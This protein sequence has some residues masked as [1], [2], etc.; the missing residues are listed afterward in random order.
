M[1]RTSLLATLLALVMASCTSEPP[2]PPTRVMVIGIDGGTWTAIDPLMKAGKLPN[3]RR[4]HDEGLH[5]ILE[6]RPPILSPVVWTTIFTGFGHDKHGVKD[7]KTSQSVHRRVSALWEITS[8]AKRKTH[9]FNVPGSWPPEPVDGVMVSGFPL[10]GSTLLGNTGEVYTR[11]GL[12]GKR[13][14]PPVRDNADLLR[15]T[16]DSLS[17][18]QW[19]PW[20][21]VR[22]TN[23]PNIRGAMRVLRLEE[24]K[25]YVSP[26]YRADDGIV[27]TSPKE[28]RGQL[29]AKLG[30]PY[31]P[32]GPGWSRWEEPDTP[33]F[34]ADHLDQV[35]DIQTKAAF[36][37]VAEDWQAFLYVMTLVDRVSHPYWAYSHPDDYEGLDRAKAAKY[38]SAVD[39]A[40]IRS[41]E[42]LGRFLAKAKEANKGDFYV[43]I[44]SDHGFQSAA[45]GSKAIGTH[46]P[47]GIF[48]LH[49]PG[50][51]AGESPR[52]FIEDVTPT[53]LYLMNLPIGRDM[54][55]QLMSAVRASLGREPTFV[56]SYE[57]AD[58]GATDVP[59]DDATWE[60]L[61][62]LG[63]VDGAP[64]RQQM[65]KDE[66][67]PAA[68]KKPGVA[69]PAKPAAPKAGAAKPPAPK[70]PGVGANGRQPIPKKEGGAKAPAA[71]AN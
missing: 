38:A 10:S 45:G 49:G 40:Y 46:N 65:Q 22:V 20:L 18:G 67:K 62:G 44:V 17:I 63:Y 51:Q 8:A 54:E 34:L 2:P 21:D 27:M 31:I 24:D 39:D 64:P 41:D 19:S 9:V 26:F 15:T 68:P 16:F 4:L 28:L 3:L 11:E 59:V 60:Q 35:F 14:I 12:L 61:R 53:I 13:V 25:F 47:D 43:M 1:R 42:A 48:L 37:Y 71:P 7:W 32:E 6:S 33:E 66:K 23:R 36:D 57:T 58:H 52:V 56:E 5:G 50:I 29:A 55:G 70:K 69:N 30:E